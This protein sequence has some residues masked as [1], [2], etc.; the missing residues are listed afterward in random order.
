M[1]IC[2]TYSVTAFVLGVFICLSRSKKKGRTIRFGEGTILGAGILL[3]KMH[4]GEPGAWLWKDEIVNG[5]PSVGAVSPVTIRAASRR[6][7][8]STLI[9]ACVHI[10][11]I[12][13]YAAFLNVF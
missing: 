10:M 4:Q 3:S 8:V 9:V 11:P 12:C 1:R 13:I 2:Y 7:E 5:E 6:V